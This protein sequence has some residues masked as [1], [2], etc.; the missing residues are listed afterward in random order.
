MP[1][2]TIDETLTSGVARITLRR[3]D[4]RN[5]LSITLRRELAGALHRAG[6]GRRAGCTLIT[7][8]GSTFCAGMDVTQF[9]GDAANRLAIAESTEVFFRALLDHPVPLVA[10][11]NGAALGGGFVLALLC[12]IRIAAASAS[13]GFPEAA[14]GI[15]PSYAAARAALPPA[16]ARDLA[17]TGRVVGADEAL[18]LGVVS[19][20]VPDDELADRAQELAASIAALPERA[21]RTVREWIHSD[22]VSTAEPA[23]ADEQA[24]LRKALGL[25]REP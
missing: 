15:P 6:A 21:P 5:A 1:E 19:R 18:A 13:F 10:A 22:M 12:D 14:R 20:V 2:G 16:V 3:E 23:F 4:Q 8:A 11:V 7:G 17:L 24:L 9:G 25:D